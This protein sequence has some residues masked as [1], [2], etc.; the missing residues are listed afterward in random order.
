MPGIK[1]LPDRAARLSMEV[2]QHLWASSRDSSSELLLNSTLACV[3]RCSSAF[4]AFAAAAR[5]D[6]SLSLHDITW[7]TSWAEHTACLGAF[8]T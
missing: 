4:V 7:A 5:K 1:I 3:M 8:Y 2:L 6:S